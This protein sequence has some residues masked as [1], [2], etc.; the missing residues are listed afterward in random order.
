VRNAYKVS[1]AD[2]KGRD[3]IEDVGVDGRRVLKCIGNK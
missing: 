2:P 3:N 1:V